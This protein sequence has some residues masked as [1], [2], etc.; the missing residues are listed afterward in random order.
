[1]MQTNTPEP[2]MSLADYLL[3]P[4]DGRFGSGPDGVTGRP[5]P[6]SSSVFVDDLKGAVALRGHGFGRVAQHRRGVRRHDDR[7]FWMALGNT[8]IDAVLVVSAVG[9]ERGYRARDLIKKAPTSAPSSTSLA[10]SDA[11]PIQPVPAPTPMCSFLQDRRVLVPCFSSSHSP[12]PQSFRP[13]LS[14]SRCKSSPSRRGCRRGTSSVSVRQLKVE[15][16]GTRSSTPS[17]PMPEQADDGA[18][19]TLGLAQRQAEHRA[20]GERRQDG[21]RRV[22]GLPA[23]GVARRCPPALDRLVR[24]PDSRASALAQGRIVGGRVDGSVFLSWDVVATVAVQLEGQGGFQGQIRSKLLTSAYSAALQ[25]AS[26]Q[27]AD[28]SGR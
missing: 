10:V 6:G 21:E 24:E 14:T 25:A 13:V 12:A 17:R 28:E 16:S 4:A 19:Q 23:W 3:E 22:A 8:G 9:D 11:A 20:Q 15:W 18:D 2:N 1:M 5:L 7:R 26:V 27:H